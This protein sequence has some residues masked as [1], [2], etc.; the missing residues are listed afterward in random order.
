M[1]ISSTQQS[2]FISRKKSYK[3]RKNSGLENGTIT[4]NPFVKDTTDFSYIDSKPNTPL[5][6]GD[7][8]KANGSAL[9]NHK[10]KEVTIAPPPY[11]KT[12]DPQDDVITITT[13]TTPKPSAPP[14]P[15]VANG[16]VP[17]GVVPL[18]AVTPANPAGP[19]SI[20]SEPPSM[21]DVTTLRSWPADPAAPTGDQPGYIRDLNDLNVQYIDPSIEVKVENGKIEKPKKVMD[22][23][24]HSTDSDNCNNNNKSRVQ[25]SESMPLPAKDQPAGTNTSPK[26]NHNTSDKINNHVY[27]NTIFTRLWS[28]DQGPISI[29]RP[30]FLGM[31]IPMFKMRQLWDRLMFKMGIHI[32]VRWHLYIETVPRSMQSK[33]FHIYHAFV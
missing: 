31:G 8:P 4:T 21:R 18:S 15:P 10:A 16:S 25:R 2:T 24:R 14:P 32:L 11:T 33:L 1:L 12:G 28:L 26:A 5:P 9:P 19:G 29:K 30:S 22:P 7:R 3:G 6:G 27:E 23:M 17:S 20:H 13:T